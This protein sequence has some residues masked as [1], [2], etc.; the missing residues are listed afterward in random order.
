MRLP[1]LMSELIPASLAVQSI[2]EHLRDSNVA[3]IHR[4]LEN[5]MVLTVIWS[6][7]R[8]IKIDVDEIEFAGSDFFGRIVS[9]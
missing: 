7:F 2:P 1:G 6:C 4:Y 8:L 3:H 5:Y 9:D